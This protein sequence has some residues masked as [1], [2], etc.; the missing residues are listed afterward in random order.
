MPGRIDTLILKVAERCN[1]NCS[2]CY[3]YQH[4]DRGF[5]YRPKIMS[6]E[7]FDQVLVRVKEYC[8][9][10]GSYRMNLTMHGGEPTLNGA[11]RLGRLV[12]RAHEVL[13]QHLGDISMQTNA[14]LIDR[15]WIQTIRHH[16]IRVGVSL[17]GPAK[18]H[19]RVRVDHT[20]RGSHAAT[21][22]GLRLLQKAG[23]SP[24]VLCVINP[25]VVGLEVY[26]YFRS[27][28]VKKIDFLLPDVSHD[29]K[30]RLYGHCGVTPV[31]DYLI[32]VFNQWFAEDDPEV[33]IRLFW[34]LISAMMGGLQ[35]TDAFGNPLMSYLII[36]TD[37]SIQA[38]D[39]LRVCEDGIADSGLNVLQHGFDD[40]HVGLPL[41][42]QVVH[43][44]I[45]LSAV[46]EACSEREICGGGYLPHRYSRDK[47]FNNPSV[48]C[49]DILKLLAHIRS[50]VT[51]AV[52]V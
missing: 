21:L 48:W 17:D 33:R 16:N 34:S 40:L 18:L 11:Q 23:L 22:R 26:R 28:G 30:D 49:K 46:C 13:Q 6:D 5:L 7:V 51:D 19:D 44:G 45:P 4:A 47:G 41:V 38:L 43:E 37:G 50:Q 2:Y 31:A 32:P 52:S 42:H 12:E 14:T 9:R 24:G 3:I 39:A 10:R 35:K 8:D 27:L 15:E 20:G 36:E 25:E 1:L 29:N